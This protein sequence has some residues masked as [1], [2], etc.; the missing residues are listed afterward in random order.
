MERKIKQFTY[1]LSGLSFAYALYVSFIKHLVKVTPDTHEFMGSQI[2]N[3][4]NKNFIESTYH[5][6]VSIPFALIFLV[7]GIT[8]IIV[9][10]YFE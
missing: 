6:T 3:S 9:N 5:Y 8:I 10:K 2:S 4:F 1:G 7:F